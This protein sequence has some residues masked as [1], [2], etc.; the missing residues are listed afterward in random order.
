VGTVNLGKENAMPEE[1][2]YE[3]LREIEGY[4]VEVLEIDPARKVTIYK[5]LIPVL[6]HLPDGTNQVCA[7][8]F[9]FCQN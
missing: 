4:P 3:I 2:R 1:V 5:T 8:G 9:D 6:T 7:T